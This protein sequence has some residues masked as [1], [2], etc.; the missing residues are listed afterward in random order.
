MTTAPEGAQ[1]HPLTDAEEEERQHLM[2]LAE[3]GQLVPDTFARCVAL[4]DR[5][6]AAPRVTS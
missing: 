6:Q 5:R 4:N 2:A 3:A 1:L